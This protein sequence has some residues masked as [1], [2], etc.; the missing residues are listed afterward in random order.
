MKDKNSERW[1]TYV[2]VNIGS[3]KDEDLYTL[4]PEFRGMS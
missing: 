4:F 2:L 1:L 3:T